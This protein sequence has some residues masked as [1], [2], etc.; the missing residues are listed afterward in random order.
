MNNKKKYTDNDI[1]CWLG[2]I[3]SRLVDDKPFGALDM[4]HRYEDMFVRRR[5]E[6]DK[7]E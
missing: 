4:I 5:N 2:V 6:D 3:K 1:L 7:N